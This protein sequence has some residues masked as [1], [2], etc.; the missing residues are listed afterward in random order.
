MIPRAHPAGRGLTYAAEAGHERYDLPPLPRGFCWTYG[1]LRSP[2][3][4]IELYE[5]RAD[6]LGR[7]VREE[8]A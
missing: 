3:G 6:G 2:V 5:A 8:D 7:M 4:T 1:E